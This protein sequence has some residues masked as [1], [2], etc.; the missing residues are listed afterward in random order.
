VATSLANATDSKI[1]EESIALGISANFIEALADITDICGESGALLDMT[2]AS[3]RPCKAKSNFRVHKEMTVTLR[4][5]GKALKA[6]L[7]ENDVEVKGYITDLHKSSEN[8]D[9][10][11]IKIRTIDSAKLVH[12]D[13]LNLDNYNKAVDA[14]KEDKIIVLKGDMQHKAKKTMLKNATILGIRS[15]IE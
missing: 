6:R 4:E 7:P 15:A 3:V 1:I 14:H 11:S 2:W 9:I 5:V 12:I 10:G 13:C 8:P